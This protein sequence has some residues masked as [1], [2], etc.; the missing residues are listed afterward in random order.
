MANCSSK[1]GNFHTL[2]ERWLVLRKKFNDPFQLRIATTIFYTR[3]EGGHVKN[4]FRQNLHDL[5]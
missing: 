4:K 2:P 5:C 3:L 1:N